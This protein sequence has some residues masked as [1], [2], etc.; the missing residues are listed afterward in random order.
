MSLVFP[1]VN[2]LLALS[3]AHV[4]QGSALDWWRR[5]PGMIGFCRFTQLGL[6][7]LLTTPGV[8]GGKPLT[9]RLAWKTYD[10]LLSDERVQFVTE[11]ESIE[12]DLRRFSSGANASPKL[13]ADAYLLAFATQLGGVLVTFDRAL[14]HR[15]AHNMLLD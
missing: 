4:H 6:L 10:Q 15:A 3:I 1:D 9:M 13:W 11:P 2:V 5:E 14:A 7:R 12:S 8:M